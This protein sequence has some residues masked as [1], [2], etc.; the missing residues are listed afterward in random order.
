MRL[1]V[2]SAM[3]PRNSRTSSW[4]LHDR[5]RSRCNKS[6]SSRVQAD[7]IELRKKERTASSCISILGARAPFVHDLRAGP[8][9]HDCARDRRTTDALISC[10]KKA[11]AAQDPATV[12][13]NRI[14][15]QP[16]IKDRTGTLAAK[17]PTSMA[18]A[19]EQIRELG[20]SRSLYFDVDSI[21]TRRQTWKRSAWGRITTVLDE[22]IAF[23]AP[24]ST[25]IDRIGFCV[26]LRRQIRGG[27]MPHAGVSLPTHFCGGTQNMIASAVMQIGA[28]SID[29]LPL[30]G[31]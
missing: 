13:A 10:P 18:S 5:S 3:L 28:P 19:A 7:L 25:E 14:A 1:S 24:C 27:P 21:W 11:N 31:A 26:V 30:E 9:G 17:V 6:R 15:C 29:C 16:T 2:T 4:K 8:R 12:L 23:A 20:R 22:P